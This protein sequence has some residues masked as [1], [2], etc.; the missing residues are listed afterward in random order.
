MT[1]TAKA[2]TTTK[3]TNLKKISNSRVRFSRLVLNFFLAL[4]RKE[5]KEVTVDEVS[6]DGI[7]SRIEKEKQKVRKVL[8]KQ[9]AAL[10]ELDGAS[11]KDTEKVD[12]EVEEL[13]KQIKEAQAA[14][15]KKLADRESAKGAIAAEKERG[16]KIL[17]NIDKF[18]G[19]SE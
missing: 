9:T 19:E 8:E 13:E 4:L 5:T 12:S 15:Q 3:G 10:N 16:E 7:F 6:L 2:M 14:L 11:K 17:A 18:Y 1:E